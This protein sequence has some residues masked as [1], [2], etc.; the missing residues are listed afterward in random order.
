MD[1]LID[2]NILIDLLAK[3]EGFYEDSALIF[4]VC[5]AGLANGH[6]SALSISDTIYILRKHL[7]PEKTNE[8]IK[9]L[10]TLVDFE[11]I[12]SSD[13][14]AAAQRLPKDFEDAVQDECASRI[15]VDF[16]VTRNLKHF[17]GSKVKAITPLSLLNY[18]SLN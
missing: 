10:H 18:L 1:V 7:S 5:D 9:K 16:I 11:D 14:L 8:M 6:I 4:K 3:R 17:E 13:I 12:K 15:G 2:T